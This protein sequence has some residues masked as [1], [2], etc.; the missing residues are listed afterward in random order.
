MRHVKGE[1]DRTIG[2]VQTWVRHWS[3]GIISLGYYYPT[4]EGEGEHD[5]FEEMIVLA[6]LTFIYF[7]SLTMWDPTRWNLEEYVSKKMSESEIKWKTK[8][9]KASKSTKQYQPYRDEKALN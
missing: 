2:Q 4:L 8:R 1:W 3:N 7:I 5:L 9:K 6:G